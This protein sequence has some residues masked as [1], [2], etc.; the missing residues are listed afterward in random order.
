MIESDERV[1]PS[2]LYEAVYD[3]FHFFLDA[4]ASAANAKTFHYCGLDRPAA[5]LA[6]LDTLSAEP[7][8]NLTIDD[9]NHCCHG[10][11]LTASW[12]QLAASL[13]RGRSVWLNP[14]YSRGSLMQWCAKAE[15]ESQAGLTVVL[16]I[17]GDTSTEYF[18]RYALRHEHR[19]INRRLS[20]EGAPRDKQG[21]LAPPAKFGSLLVVMR[22]THALWSWS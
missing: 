4:A 21:R 18:H 2:W 5:S 6:P 13:Q 16:L 7:G 8:A 10:D 12:V 19:F 22:P 14:P 11:G 1:T 20:F 17:P 9:P 3:E 15:L